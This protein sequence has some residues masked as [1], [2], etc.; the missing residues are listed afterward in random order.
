[1]KYK[2]CMISL[3]LIAIL[4]IGNGMVIF[5]ADSSVTYEGGAEKFVFLPGSEYSDS[6]L[7]DGF[8]NVMP[9]DKLQ[10]TI[11][12]ENNSRSSDYVRIYMRAEVHEEDSD[13]QEF[14]NQLSMTVHNGGTQ[15]Y[16]ASPDELDGLAENVLLGEFR[17]GESTELTVELEVPIEMDN[18]YANRIGEVDWVF[19]VEEINDPD[20]VETGD[21]ASMLLWIVLMLAAAWIVKKRLAVR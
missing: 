15:I 2:K 10:E 4:V 13:M 19:V 7:F 16:Q 18:T 11:I 20:K 14:L 9:G 8:K 17:P 1:M 21:S 5:A 3:L 6:D 12:V